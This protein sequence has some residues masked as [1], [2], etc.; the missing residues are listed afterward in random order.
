MSRL[1][2]EQLE[3]RLGWLERM[4]S[5]A[6][7]KDLPALNQTYQ[8]IMDELARRD[9]EQLDNDKFHADRPARHTDNR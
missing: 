3:D 9:L 7:P 2:T 6:S 4:M 8:K 5:T 1:T